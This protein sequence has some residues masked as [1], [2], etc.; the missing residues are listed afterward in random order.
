MHDL[1][2]VTSTEGKLFL[3][4]AQ[5]DTLA[6]W[7]GGVATGLLCGVFAAVGLSMLVVS[8]IRRLRGEA[9]AHPT[10]RRH[11]WRGIRRWTRTRSVT[12]PRHTTAITAWAVG[13]ATGISATFTSW[14]AT[15]SA[16]A[17]SESGS[18]TVRTTGPASVPV[19]DFAATP[20]G[21]P[22]VPADPPDARAP[23]TPTPVAPAIP[24]S[25]PT[26]PPPA[27]PTGGG[28]TGGRPTVRTHTVVAGEHF[29]LIASNRVALELGRHPDDHEVIRYWRQL[30]EANRDRL[31]D[32]NDPDLIHPGLELLLP[33][34]QPGGVTSP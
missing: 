34:P 6:T 30:I 1:S 19:L 28:S 18:E 12:G 11:R 4:T 29:W 16:G 17:V 5:L 14:A 9:R 23:E 2:A 15:G 21:S 10:D 25:L 13:I 3:D 22:P 7:A 32:A 26:E 27:L 33:D 24:R 31:I 20:A 8:P